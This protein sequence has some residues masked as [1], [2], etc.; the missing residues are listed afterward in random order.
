MITVNRESVQFSEQN[1]ELET[2]HRI[3][4]KIRP[5]IPVTQRKPLT[6]F[7]LNTTGCFTIS[8]KSDTPLF[9]DICRRSRLSFHVVIGHCCGFDFLKKKF[10]NFFRVRVRTRYKPSLVFRLGLVLSMVKF[11]AGIQ[12]FGLKTTSHGKPDPKNSF[13]RS[14]L[15]HGE[16]QGEVGVQG[17][18]LFQHLPVLCGYS[19]F[20]L[21]NHFTW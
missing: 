17:H 19:T 13:S 14:D 18:P 7:Y 4:E 10:Q 16:V 8:V 9:S 6:L 2:K 12:L 20:W 11:S 5:K 3:A 1:E 21:E 15:R